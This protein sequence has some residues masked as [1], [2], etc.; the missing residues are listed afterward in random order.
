MD[1]AT[2][3]ET[4]EH[5]G[6]T[7]EC[8]ET[9]KAR[10]RATELLSD[11]PTIEGLRELNDL[12]D[13]ASGGCFGV[14]SVTLADEISRFHYINTGDT[15][16]GT[17]GYIEEYCTNWPKIHPYTLTTWG[18][19]YENSMHERTADTGEIRCAY[20]GE[21]TSDYN[22]EYQCTNKH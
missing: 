6:M 4:L 16:S 21:W 20:C 14:E 17:V 7:A 12:F 2:I 15:Y 11:A 1:A 9:L 22:S 10:Q 5:F 13:R 3:K 18:D 19:I 8:A